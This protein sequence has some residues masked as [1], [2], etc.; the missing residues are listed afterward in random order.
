MLKTE[1]FRIFSRKIFKI[2]CVNI[3]LVEMP[4]VELKLKFASFYNTQM[5]PLFVQKWSK[6]CHF[7]P[8]MAQSE[9]L[10]DF[11][12]NHCESDPRQIRTSWR[13]KI[14]NI[15]HNYVKKTDKRSFWVIL[16]KILHNFDHFWT[17]N[18][19]IEYGK[20]PQI[21]TSILL[22]IFQL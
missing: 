5:G 17:K 4:L 3:I 15:G 8:K 12:P 6:W 18:R 16:G 7:W 20:I 11:S 10:S 19:P 22:T 14:R 13:A 2:L 21:S 1:F 9:R